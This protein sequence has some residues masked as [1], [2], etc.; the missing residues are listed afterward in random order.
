MPAD[1]AH[2]LRDALVDISLNSIEY[3]ATLGGDFGCLDKEML[4]HRAC[5]SAALGICQV[6]D[7]TLGACV[8]GKLCIR[9]WAAAHLVL[10]ESGGLAW[11]G[12]ARVAANDDASGVSLGIRAKRFHMAA[13]SAAVGESLLQSLCSGDYRESIRRLSPP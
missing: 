10:T 5:G 7:G 6:A 4:G 8:S 12:P 3:F 11:E 9:D 1:P 2:P 13:S